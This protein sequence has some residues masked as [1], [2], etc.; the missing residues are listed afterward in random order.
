MATVRLAQRPIGTTPI[1][2]MKLNINAVNVHKGECG[3]ELEAA[4]PVFDSE[5]A[6]ERE[7]TRI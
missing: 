6:R 4:P 5:S 2:K 3:L 1:P 7:I